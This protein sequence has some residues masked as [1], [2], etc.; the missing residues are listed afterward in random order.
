PGGAA[1]GHRAPLHLRL[2]HQNA[3]RLSALSGAIPAADTRPVLE[4]R[5]PSRARHLAWCG[6]ETRPERLQRRGRGALRSQRGRARNPWR[7]RGYMTLELADYER[8]SKE[9]VMA[10]WGNR[11]K[12]R[13]KQA[14]AGTLDQ[15]E[16]AGVTG[17]KNMDGFV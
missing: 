1:V 13:Q 15:G 12:A 2:L 4:R 17:G 7:R 3:R 5:S 9:A 14:E 6:E 11:E 10:F 16:R 8:Q